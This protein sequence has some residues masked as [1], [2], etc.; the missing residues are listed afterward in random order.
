LF[1]PSFEATNKNKGTPWVDV[2]LALT[3]LI[4]IAIAEILNNGRI[5][6]LVLPVLLIGVIIGARR[7]WPLW[8]LWWLGWMLF[9]AVLSILLW[10]H[11]SG[12][13]AMIY[14]LWELILAATLLS[15]G[16]AVWQRGD[17]FR[18]AFTM[19]PCALE[20][21]RFVLFDDLPADATLQHL[22]MRLAAA[23]I[24]TGVAVL[25]TQKQSRR[26]RWL[27][28]IIG[29]LAHFVT[30]IIVS[31][32]IP[33]FFFFY[34]SYLPAL[35]V[36]A[37]AP[38][39][40]G[41]GL[42]GHR[43]RRRL[44]IPTRAALLAAIALSI[45]GLL[46]PWLTGDALP[47]PPYA[48]IAVHA[49]EQRRAIIIDTDLSFDDYIAILYLLQRPDVDILGITVVNGVAHV[50]PGLEN[51]QRLLAMAGR[52]DIPVAAGSP[53]PLAGNNAFP[54]SWRII[55]DSTFRPTLP[56]PA[57]ATIAT[58]AP[59]LIRQLANDSPL[60]ISFIALGPLTN[61]AQAFQGEPALISRFDA[62]FISGGVIYI[63]DLP[64]PNS[65]SDWNLSVETLSDWN[66]SVDPHA[67]DLIFRSG[68]P[69][70]LIPL[71]ATSRYGQNPILIHE[72]FVG[73]FA[74][75]SHGRESQL[76]AHIMKGLFP[77]SPDGET[78]ALW[79]APAVAIVTDST[80]CTDWQN[81]SIHIALE[82]DEIAGK[83][84]VDKNGQ[85]NARV[86]LAGDQAAFEEAYL[87]TD[88]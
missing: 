23:F 18:V 22:L 19:F 2:G 3:P 5:S 9:V 77:V 76:M 4:P 11:S 53:V 60:P 63:E 62:V 48:P 61:L 25:V 84:I 83:T 57:T 51:V 43:A 37:F 87:A 65:V 47:A 39:V 81:L 41:L 36:L 38:L 85:P 80:I 58:T 44:S 69:I 42:D 16:L 46:P 52:E 40:A 74:A 31:L 75:T 7:R 6:P 10:L 71:D 29:A 33:F 12:R 26:A 82:P 28:L 64:D 72:D 21:I 24:Y 32:P 34:P 70:V 66:L 73:Y 59:D 67:A 54:R 78:A 56:K 88:H 45:V 14:F 30:A 15:I 86:C 8:S 1:N 17:G 27:V 50:E 20:F 49:P 55:F 68:V 13:P 35:A 79:D